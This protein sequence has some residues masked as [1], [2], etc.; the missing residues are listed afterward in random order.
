MKYQDINDNELVYLVC[1]HHEDAQTFL[2]QKY[3]PVILSM[4]KKYFDKARYLGIE[5]EDLKQEAYM[6]LSFAMYRYNED[7]DV[8][9]YTF[10]TVCM[11]HHIQNYLRRMSSTKHALL[12]ESVSYD[13]KEESMG[14]YFLDQLSLHSK[15]TPE[16][17]TAFHEIWTFL[18]DL[19]WQ[20]DFLKRGAFLLKISG[21]SNLEISILLDLSPSECKSYIGSSLRFIRNCFKKK[22][23]A[24]LSEYW[25]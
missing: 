20:M 3:E 4:T 16:E 7:K 11:E 13:G 25:L 2:F 18:Y 1:E 19:S 15:D 21:F 24:L 23:G 8:L 6:G 12:N 14:S 22:R 10:A 9:F 5:F 17:I